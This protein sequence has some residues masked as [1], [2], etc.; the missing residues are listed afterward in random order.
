VVAANFNSVLIYT[1]KRN[2][3][4]A[5][6]VPGGGRHPQGVALGMSCHLGVKLF[7]CTHCLSKR[8]VSV[9]FSSVQLLSRHPR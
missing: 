5:G 1:G 8:S 4:A 9:L 7:I 3:T 6:E 2:L